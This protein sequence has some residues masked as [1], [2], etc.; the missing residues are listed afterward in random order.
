MESLFNWRPSPRISRPS[1]RTQ[2]ALNPVHKEPRV[3][4]RPTVRYPDNAGDCVRHGWVTVGGDA[5]AGGDGG[6]S[7]A[8]R[9]LV[10]AS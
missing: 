9:G 1:M 4:E 5:Y 10:C 3:F 2:R 7:C 6:D 8:V